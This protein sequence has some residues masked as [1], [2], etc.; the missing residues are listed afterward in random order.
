MA[1]TGVCVVRHRVPVLDDVSLRIFAG[2][3]IAVL[4]PNGAGKSTLLKCLA[5]A[6]RP[7]GGELLWFNRLQQSCSSIRRPIGFLGHEHGLYWE[8]T[9]RENLVF[10]GRMYGV[11]QP[12]EH[13]ERSLKAASLV[14]IA[15]KRVAQLSQGLR[16]RVAIIRAA[17]HD[18]RL[19]LLDEPFASL[20]AQGGAWLDALFDEWRHAGKAVCFVSHDV[21]HSNALADRIV[22]LEAGRIVNVA[23]SAR[24]LTLSQRSA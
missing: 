18:P 24:R 21:H 13:A 20:D 6:M 10:A 3:T 19:V 22:T 16:Q 7:D 17:V 23:T 4:G 1:A 14:H 12:L 11:E 8:L 5:G 2:E 15:N 9:A